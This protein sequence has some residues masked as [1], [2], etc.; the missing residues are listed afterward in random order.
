MSYDF[1]AK[2]DIN[3]STAI[4][5][6]LS[7]IIEK[8]IAVGQLAPGDMLPSENEFCD[9]YQIS[10]TTVR[11]A[12]HELEKRR[13]IVRKRGL[14]TFVEEKVSRRLG[15]LYS[16]SEDM[17]GLGMVPSSKL[18]KFRLISKNEASKAVRE[19]D[20][21]YLFEVVRLR[22]ADDKPMLIERTY[23]PEN[24]FPDLTQEKIQNSPLYELL[25]KGYGIQPHRAIE[26]YEAV[27]MRKEETD[28]LQ[29]TPGQPAFMLKRSMWDEQDRL[30]EYT[31]SIMPS[32][33][34]KFEIA[35]Y[36]DGVEIKR[37]TAIIQKDSTLATNTVAE[38][39]Y[40]IIRENYS[41]PKFNI[42]YISNELHFCEAYL[43]RV[44]KKVYGKP[45]N[46]L[47]KEIR[48]EE[49]NKLV[50]RGDMLISQIC[51]QVGIEDASYFSK[52]FKEYFG[53]SPSGGR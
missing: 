37:K 50:S 24:L 47:L 11:Q 44:C 17:K 19:I 32:S 4:Y 16:F 25:Y 10:R 35:M 33:R 5:L 27:I 48:M 42:S 20:S 29:C 36:H 8:Q 41:N 53:K 30:V 40:N 39:I 46:A 26:T 6:Q 9:Y 23:L 49:A 51:L 2:L 31:V 18:L 21:E 7:D 15:S 34:S 14:G 45:P 28:H 3:S 12:L 22:I 13:H 43:R 1:S 52:C 38:K